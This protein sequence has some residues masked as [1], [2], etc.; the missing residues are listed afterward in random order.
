MQLIMQAIS[1]KIEMLAPIL[2]W[3]VFYTRIE[4]NKFPE[5][6]DKIYIIAVTYIPQDFSIWEDTINK[7]IEFE[8]I[9]MKLACKY[10]AVNHL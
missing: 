1:P 3:L 10:E 7:K 8:N 2:I 9:C 5:I 4:L 6:P